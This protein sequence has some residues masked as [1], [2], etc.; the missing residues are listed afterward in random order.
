MLLR[1]AHRRCVGVFSRP[2]GG[3]AR[4]ACE[5]SIPRWARRREGRH[6]GRAF[7]DRRSLCPR[8]MSGVA[9]ARL[10]EARPWP[11]TGACAHNGMMAVGGPGR[12]GSN[13]W[14]PPDRRTEPLGCDARAGGSCR[15]GMRVEEHSCTERAVSLDVSFRPFARTRGASGRRAARA[16]RAEERSSL[17][18]SRMPSPSRSLRCSCPRHAS[19]CQW[20]RA[21][22]DHNGPA[23][24]RGD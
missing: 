8:S 9:V 24:G 3:K 17:G 2:H 15:V 6:G 5:H 4:V 1:V 21:P 20:S 11:W 10:Q 18:R 13:R 16:P 23:F 19:T 12:M 22:Q 7:G 14:R